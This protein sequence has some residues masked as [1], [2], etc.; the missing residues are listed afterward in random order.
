MGE[1]MHFIDIAQH[2]LFYTLMLK[3]FAHD[4]AIPSSNYQ[5][6]F[7]IWVARERYMRNHFLVAETYR[8]VSVDSR[9]N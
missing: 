7:W 9:Q 1:G 4:T 5:D 8:H 3:Y 6:I 2:H